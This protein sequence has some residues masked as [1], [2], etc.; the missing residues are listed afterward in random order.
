[1]TA[2]RCSAPQADPTARAH[3]MTSGDTRAILTGAAVVVSAA[4][5]PFLVGAL[6]PE[7]RGQIRFGTAQVGLAMAV[8]YSVAGALSPLGGRLVHRLG[9]DWSGRLTCALA[10]VGSLVI[11]VAG[12]LS[13]ILTGLVV[14]GAANAL[15]Q[16]TS[17]QMLLRLHQ[18]RRQ[19]F[20]FGA[21]QAAIPTAALAAGAALAVTTQGTDWRTVSLFVTLATLLPQLLLIRP[22]RYADSV[23]RVPNPASAGAVTSR[24]RLLP[25]VLTGA[26]ASAAATA[27][28]SFTATS[29]LAQGLSPFVVA[30]A[31]IAGS[32]GSIVVRV[33]APVLVSHGSFRHR[34]TVVA[35][36]LVT[37]SGGLL[38]LTTTGVPQLFVLGT[39]LGFAF[40]WGW[41]GLY[42]QV[43]ATSAAD[44][45]ATVTGLTQAG[46]F[47]GGVAGPALFALVVALAGFGNAWLAMAGL[48][49]IASLSALAG[50]PARDATRE[51]ASGSGLKGERLP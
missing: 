33:V 43:V 13:H 35:S 11:T 25:L 19:A 28:P 20:A 31:Q 37:G 23:T 44:R 8:C 42:N 24:R 17:N 26:L 15:S 2:D 21:V 51:P 3:T 34:F 32:L 5:P 27:L 6:A 12:S 16:P 49:A 30:G 48:M 9:S 1:M 29:G 22:L 4:V 45:V 7:I 40:G 36:L 10:T 41:N 46:V 39:V 14:V 38:L 47:L 50:R 18:P